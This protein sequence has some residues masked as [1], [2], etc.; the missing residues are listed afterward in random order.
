[1]SFNQ[2]NKQSVFI[3]LGL[4]KLKATKNALESQKYLKTE[5]KLTKDQKLEMIFL[6][7]S[8]TTT[9]TKK[10]LKMIKIVK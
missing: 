7:V 5:Y 4:F 1:M 10:K 9:T 8:S 3:C 2:S 6:F